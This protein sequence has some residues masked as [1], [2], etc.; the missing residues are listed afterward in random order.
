MIKKSILS[1]NNKILL[2]VLGAL[3]VS[4]CDIDMPVE[5]G[6][7]SA[8]FNIH[9]TVTNEQ[10][11]PLQGIAVHAGWYYD[12]NTHSRRWG[13]ADTTGTDGK[14]SI[15][16]SGIGLI[17]APD[18]I[19]FSDADSLRSPGYSDTADALSFSGIRP[20]GGDGHWYAGTYSIKKDVTLTKK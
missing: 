8:D 10:H 2:A 17:E 20:E 3:G 16:T 19:A 11:E 13:V 15:K 4:A 14:Y 5:Y 18:S 1:A 6:C 7:P 12:S 9:G